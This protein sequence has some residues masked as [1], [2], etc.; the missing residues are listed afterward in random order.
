MLYLV[1]LPPVILGGIFDLRKG[2]IPNYLTFTLIASGLVFNII[3]GNAVMSVL[4][5]GVAFAIGYFFWNFIGGIGG[6]DV[7]LIA[8][9]GAW[10]GLYPLTVILLFSSLFGLLWFALRFIREKAF[11]KILSGLL[12]R[13]YF[14][15]VI[16]LKNLLSEDLGKGGT[17][18]YGVCIA[19]G[20]II[21]LIVFKGEMFLL[22]FL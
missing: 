7:K 13:L 17:I 18:P 19:V 1:L 11:F 4:G 12:A 10:L 16:G 21:A 15:R 9:I 14:I 6:G 5:F 22:S 20:Y 2:I 8:G 3:N